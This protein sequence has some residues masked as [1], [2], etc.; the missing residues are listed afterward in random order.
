MGGLKSE[1]IQII[2]EWCIRLSLGLALLCAAADRLGLWGQNGADNVGWGDWGHLVQYCGLDNCF[3]QSN[4]A[5]SLAWVA[6]ALETICGIGLISGLFL[7]IAA[8][9]TF[10]LMV[11]FALWTIITLGVRTP[12]NHSLFVDAAAALALAA[13]VDCRKS[14]LVSTSIVRIEDLT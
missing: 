7:R 12:V 6:A 8:Y 13:M 9:S 10:F 1:R 3:L 14:V 4:W 11:S 2:A 5:G